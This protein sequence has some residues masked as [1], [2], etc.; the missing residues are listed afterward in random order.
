VRTAPTR[1]DEVAREL[2]RR[3]QLEFQKQGIPL[4]AI[5]RLELA[6]AALFPEGAAPGTPGEGHPRAA[7]S[8]VPIT[9]SL[10]PRQ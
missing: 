10:E 5:Q 3:I 8:E 9:A 4:A 6:S 7:H 1:Q 2:R